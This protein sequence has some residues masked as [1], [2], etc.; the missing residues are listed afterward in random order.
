MDINMTLFGQVVLVWIVIAMAITIL[1]AERKTETPAI[2][3]AL[4]FMLS[5]IPPLSIIFL[6]VLAL[7]KD[8]V[9]NEVTA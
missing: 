6:V 4:S 7:K 9:K 2:T 8:A 1:L 3:I 5:F